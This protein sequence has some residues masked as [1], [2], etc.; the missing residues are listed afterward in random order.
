LRDA[1]TLLPVVHCPSA[2]ADAA[3]AASV[4]TALEVWRGL[5]PVAI[6]K[7]GPSPRLE[8]DIKV[9]PRSIDLQV[10]LLELQRVFIEYGR[11]S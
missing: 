7:T 9:V 10:P 5:N 6:P 2:P 3:M 4:A 11:F 1:W 8:F